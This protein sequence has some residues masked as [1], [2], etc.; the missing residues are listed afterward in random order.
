M[1]KYSIIPSDG[2]VSKDGVG[3]SG[4]TFSIDSTI[5]AVQWDGT[6]GEI[7]YKQTADGKPEN[8]SFD[9]I[10]DFQSAVDAWDAADAAVVDDTPTAEETTR[11]TAQTKLAASDWT[12]LADTGL[13]S[14]CVAEFATYRASLRAIRKNPTADPT[15][16][17]EPTEVW[18]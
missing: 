18:G 5:H 17:T 1:A 2:F 9:D 7:E 13:T 14:A 3:Y 11:I 10:T 6:S 16:P 15:W 12:Q 4:L 8:A